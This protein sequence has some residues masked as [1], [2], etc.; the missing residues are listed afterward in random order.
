MKKLMLIIGTLMIAGS[1][2]AHGFEGN[3]EGFYGRPYGY[4]GGRVI[5]N[6]VPVYRGYYRHDCD[7]ER[8]RDYEHDRFRDFDHDRYHRDFDR[9]GR[10]YR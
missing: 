1:I 2:S 10:Y 7:R 8:F 5:I 4:Y 3:R 9:D 6:T